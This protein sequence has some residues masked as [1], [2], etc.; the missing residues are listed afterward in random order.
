MAKRFI[1]DVPVTMR[2]SVGVWADSEEEAKDKIWEEGFSVVANTDEN[3]ADT[4]VYDWEWEM[5]ER[6]TRGNVYSGVINEM[7]VYPD[8]DHDD[9]DEE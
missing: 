3:A 9:E 8:P 4:E 5:H 7:D 2:V 1:V 6:V